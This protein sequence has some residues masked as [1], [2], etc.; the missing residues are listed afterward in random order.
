MLKINVLNGEGTSK[1]AATVAGL[2][3]EHFN[4]QEKVLEVAETKDADNWDYTQTEI[5]YSTSRDGVEELARQIQEFLGAGVIKSS[6]DNAENV[7]ITI[8]LGSYY[9]WK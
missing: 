6:Q 5:I 3:S 4:A 9:T 8:I 7:D 1:L 2:I